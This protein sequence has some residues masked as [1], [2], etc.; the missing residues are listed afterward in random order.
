MLLETEVPTALLVQNVLFPLTVL[1]MKHE[2]YVVRKEG[3][4]GRTCQNLTVWTRMR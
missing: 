1:M 3:K 2:N 4:M